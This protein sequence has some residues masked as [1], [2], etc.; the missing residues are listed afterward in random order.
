M[1]RI[2]LYSF[3]V[4]H[5]VQSAKLML[6][7]KGADFEYATVIPGFHPLM[8]RAAGFKGGTV[9]A[10]KVDGRRIQGTTAI[11]RALDELIPERPLFPADP[12]LRARVEAAE[13]WGD[14]VLQPMPRRV[15]RWSLVNSP[16][17]TEWLIGNDVPW[18]PAKRLNA[19]LNRPL[20]VFHAKRIGATDEQVRI[21]IANMD[22][23]LTHVEALID[24]G[25]IGTD[26]PNAADFQI[27]PSIR[28]CLAAP[29]VA[30]LIGE[31]PAADF[32]RRLLPKYPG[33]PIPLVLPK[34]V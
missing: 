15:F 28:V 17:A 21:D 34:D 22:D 30:E 6:E 29:V 27:A 13:A 9:P 31:R 20:S 14:E 16:V 4:S 2:R 3:G 18:L 8:L 11:S 24:E 32:A 1:S 19:R 12:S 26:Q 7:H 10:M 33:E 23:V 5:P 25:V